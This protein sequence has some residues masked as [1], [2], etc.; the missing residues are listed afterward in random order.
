MTPVRHLSVLIFKAGSGFFINKK[1][2]IP[3]MADAQLLS[4]TVLNNQYNSLHIRRESIIQ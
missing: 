3:D 1:T 2:F 4:V